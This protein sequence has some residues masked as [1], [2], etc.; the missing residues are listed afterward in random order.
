MG[1]AAVV[2]VTVIGTLVAVGLGAMVRCATRC[3]GELMPIGG[4]DMVVICEV[5]FCLLGDSAST[6]GISPACL[7]NTKNFVTI[8]YR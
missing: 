1:V 2:M 3:C 6:S 8:M 5:F 4:W 7:K